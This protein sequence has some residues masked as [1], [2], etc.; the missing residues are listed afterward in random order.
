M[1]GRGSSEEGRRDNR[2]GQ[3][4]Q[5]QCAAFVRSWYPRARHV[6]QY[7]GD[8]WQSDLVNVGPR[9]SEITMEPFNRI[10]AKLR[11]AEQAAQEQG[12]TEFHVWKHI[13][14]GEHESGSVADSAVIMRARVY[15]PMAAELDM[16]R[17]FAER[18]TPAA[19]AE[20]ARFV[21]AYRARIEQAS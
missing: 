6:G 19:Q 14:R 21:R 10:A 4:R 12:V 11:Q 8:R 5:L 20:L 2:K 15:W 16:F 17:E 13:G 3:A 18:A 9:V 7:P 1:A